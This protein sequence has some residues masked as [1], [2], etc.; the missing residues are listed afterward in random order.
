MQRRGR[1]FVTGV[2]RGADPGGTAKCRM[3]RESKSTK[4]PTEV[5]V[6]TAPRSVRIGLKCVRRSRVLLNPAAVSSLSELRNSRQAGI[7]LGII[8]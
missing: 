8:C 3:R 1:L 4:V 6:S 2:H 5:R 7:E